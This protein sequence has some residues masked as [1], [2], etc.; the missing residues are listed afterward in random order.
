MENNNRLFL[1]ISSVVVVAALVF[2][3]A[4]GFFNGSAGG[5]ATGG[6]VN[7]S[8]ES[9]GDSSSGATPGEDFKVA[10]SKDADADADENNDDEDDEDDEDDGKAAPA[11]AP[12]QGLIKESMVKVQEE[13]TAGLRDTRYY[14]QKREYYRNKFKSRQTDSGNRPNNWLYYEDDKGHYSKQEAESKEASVQKPL[15]KAEEP[16]ALNEE[17]H[18]K[19]R[20][21]NY[22]AH[23]E[24]PDDVETYTMPSNILYYEDDSHHVMKPSDYQGNKKK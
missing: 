3:D 11:P 10:D 17:T 13:P 20:N 14:E 22:Q 18:V 23:Y 15:I 8:N 1:I 16:I 6:S 12:T 5:E 21:A 7:E 24:I 4:A 19:A 2:A 9:I